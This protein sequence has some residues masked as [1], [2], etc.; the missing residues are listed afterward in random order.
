MNPINQGFA[1]IAFVAFLF[2]HYMLIFY[3]H[4][5]APYYQ[6]ASIAPLHRLELPN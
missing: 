4:E 1:L 5:Q 3:P 2:L 6:F